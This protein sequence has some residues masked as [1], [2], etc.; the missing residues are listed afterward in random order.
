M[1]TAILSTILAMICV[2]PSTS[3]ALEVIETQRFTVGNR[4]FLQKRV[5]VSRKPVYETHLVVTQI[6][7]VTPNGF[8]RK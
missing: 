4:V 1:K 7:W 8:K 2:F 5:V 3:Q 6:G